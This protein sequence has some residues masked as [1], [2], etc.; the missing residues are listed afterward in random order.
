VAAELAGRAVGGA[1]RKVK[2][3]A[4]QRETRVVS[5]QASPP[6]DRGRFELV[7]LQFKGNDT[8][9]VIQGAFFQFRSVTQH[10]FRAHGLGAGFTSGVATSADSAKANASMAS[11]EQTLLFAAIVLLI[12]LFFRG[13]LAPIVPLIAVVLVAGGAGGLIVLSAKVLGYQFDTNTPQLITTVLIGIG[14]DY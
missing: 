12:L 8:D 2:P 14:T 1:G 6:Q 9:P 7:S 3:S 10:Q 4:G 13:I 11:L 5:A